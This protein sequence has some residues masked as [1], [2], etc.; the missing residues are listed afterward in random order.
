M[1]ILFKDDIVKK[2]GKYYAKIKKFKPNKDTTGIYDKVSSWHKSSSYPSKYYDYT[3]RAKFKPQDVGFGKYGYYSGYD[4]DYYSKMYIPEY[5]INK[6]VEI[7]IHDTFSRNK[8]R[9]NNE[10]KINVWFDTAENIE[11]TDNAIINDAYQKD[12]LFDEV[13]KYFN[14][15]KNNQ[16]T[17]EQK[18]QA[19]QLYSQYLDT[20]FPDSKVKDIVYHGTL[21]KIESFD[22]SKIGKN[23]IKD[24]PKGFYF[25]RKNVAEN[26]VSTF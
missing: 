22:K 13:T 8:K 5:I 25:T 6:E 7:D 17:P 23:T 15:R 9:L 3:I 11:D 12:P 14:L 10:G 20:I 1:D 24:R 2:N 21:D 26:S 19:Q 4:N 18:Q 16:I